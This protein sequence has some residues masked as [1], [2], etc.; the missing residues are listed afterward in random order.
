MASHWVP[1]LTND[2]LINL[3]RAWPALTEKTVEGVHFVQEDSPDEI[4]PGHAL[5]GG[6]WAD[7]AMGGIRPSRS[8]S[9]G[10]MTDRRHR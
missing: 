6:R 5:D 1:S 10:L 9:I 4:G 8:S 2:T 7:G 3:V